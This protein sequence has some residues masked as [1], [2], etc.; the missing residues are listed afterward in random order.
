MRCLTTPCRRTATDETDPDRCRYL[1]GGVDPADSGAD[2]N[3]HP[4]GLRSGD[5]R[6]RPAE[7]QDQTWD[8]VD[9]RGGD[10]G[11]DLGGV[12][13]RPSGGAGAGWGWPLSI[14]AS[15]A[16]AG[17]RAGR[18]GIPRRHDQDPTIAQPRFEQDREGPR[19][20]HRSPAVRRAGFAVRQRRW[21]HSGQPAAVLCPRDRHRGAAAGVVRVV[22][23]R[24]GQC[25]VE[26]RQLHR[27][28]RRPGG[29]MYGH[30]QRRVRAD[31]LL[32]VP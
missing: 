1:A 21:P 20:D 30:G 19:P 28:T 4:A 16:G 14:R 13:R 32:A 11:R 31:H 9:G 15:G 7:S 8:A 5:P 27:W 12:L 18:G 17:N 10:P 26:R 22:R 29:R 23:H 2:P 25:M 6:G 3:V 24:R